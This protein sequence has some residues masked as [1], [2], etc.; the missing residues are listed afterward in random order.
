MIPLALNKDEGSAVR[1][2]VAIAIIGGL[3]VGT[4]LTLYVIPSIYDY[5]ET[6][7]AEKA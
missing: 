6:K 2:V 1:S 3:V 5:V 7:R 4:L